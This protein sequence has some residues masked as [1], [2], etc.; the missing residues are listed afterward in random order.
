MTT[1]GQHTN[2]APSPQTMVNVVLS[3]GD[4]DEYRKT[5]L[6]RDDMYSSDT[7]MFDYGVEE[8][9]SSEEDKKVNPKKGQ[10][11][12]GAPFKKSQPLGLNQKGT[13]V[14]VPR[15]A[16]C[17]CPLSNLNT[18]PLS[19]PQRTHYGGLIRISRN[20]RR[21]FWSWI[22]RQNSTGWIASRFA[23]GNVGFTSFVALKIIWSASESIA[24]P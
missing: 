8:S 7:S 23:V 16:R 3:D 19:S 5:E 14:V 24:N 18:D 17:L 6:Y 12:D 2:K 15:K 20:L 11:K 4:D 21:K 13:Q 22:I 9:S 1:V 10:M